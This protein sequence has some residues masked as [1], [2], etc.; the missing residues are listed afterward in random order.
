MNQP[1][2]RLM[3]HM[4]GHSLLYNK[5]TATN[6]GDEDTKESKSKTTTESNLSLGENDRGSG[7]KEPK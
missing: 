4:L 2:T 1:A 7:I 5:P 6:G 3:A